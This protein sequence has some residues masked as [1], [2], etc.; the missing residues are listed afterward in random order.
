L[1]KQKGGKNS[2]NSLK[3]KLGRWKNQLGRV[4]GITGQVRG[5]GEI[6]CRPEGPSQTARGPGWNST[7]RKRG[8][9]IP[10][11]GVKKQNPKMNI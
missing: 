6:P 9:G 2:D 7:D 1:K 11:G 4:A 5:G 8:A 3:H 10:G